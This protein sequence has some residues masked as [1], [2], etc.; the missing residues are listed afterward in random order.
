VSI[1]R[2]SRSCQF[3]RAFLLAAAGL[4][5]GLGGRTSLQ[6]ADDG[7]PWRELFDGKSLA[8]WKASNAPEIWSIQDGQLIARPAAVSSHLFF[9]GEHTPF[10]FFRDFELEVVARGG[11]NANSGVFFH[12][13]FETFPG[14]VRLRHGYEVQLCT[15]LTEKRKTGSLYE[16]VDIASPPVPGDEWFL[17]RIV[18]RG[19]RI[20]V[21]VN[22]RLLVDYTEPPDVLAQR[23]EL[24]QGRILTAAGGAIALQAHSG[25]GP[26][27]FKS[28]RLR[29]R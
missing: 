27:Y 1:I 2:P 12:T 11:K 20:T 10:E 29:T 24:R 17:T 13:D 18:V 6:A 16:I 25:S 26:F 22:D 19:K 21:H 4:I 9:V 15:S 23:T 14:T 28:I 7:P 8:G 5:L 3:R